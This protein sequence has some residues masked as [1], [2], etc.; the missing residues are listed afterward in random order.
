MIWSDMVWNLSCICCRS[1]CTCEI[2]QNH[3]P[4]ADPEPP[5][6]RGSGRNPG[7]GEAGGRGSS[8]SWASDLP[9][10][11]PFSCRVTLGV[12][13]APPVWAPLPPQICWAFRQFD[14][15]EALG[16]EGRAAWR[17][18]GCGAEVAGTR[19]SREGAV[20]GQMRGVGPGDLSRRR[21]PHPEARGGSRGPAVSAGEASANTA[22]RDRGP[23]GRSEDAWVRGPCRRRPGCL[24]LGPARTPLT[25]EVRS[26][27]VLGS[28]SAISPVPSL[29]VGS[30]TVTDT[31]VYPRRRPGRLLLATTEAFARPWGIVGA[32]VG[33]TRRKGLRSRVLLGARPRPS[34]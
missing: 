9:S 1:V 11:V 25:T 31:S 13:E 26:C 32:V 18:E 24:G 30:Q 14:G 23:R 21:G 17:A 5:S 4:H 19:G 7:P 29:A 27:T 20:Q 15:L 6:Q 2:K 12:R 22:S 10:G 8:P 34:P 16:G 33:V 3:S 28:V